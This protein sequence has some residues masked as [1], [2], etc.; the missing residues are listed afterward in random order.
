MK[1]IV[2]TASMFLYFCGWTGWWQWS[3]PTLM[4]LFPLQLSSQFSS[5]QCRE[6]A[7]AKM[8]LAK[9]DLSWELNGAFQV[10]LWMWGGWLHFYYIRCL[11]CKKLHKDFVRISNTYGVHLAHAVSTVLFPSTGRCH[12]IENVIHKI[13]TYKHMYMYDCMYVFICLCTYVYI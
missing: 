13:Y 3:F 4:I 7:V 2:F 9:K 8:G 6:T 12:C 5:L 1:S 10:A 11:F